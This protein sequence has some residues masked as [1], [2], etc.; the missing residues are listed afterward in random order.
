MWCA[1]RTASRLIEQAASGADRALCRTLRAAVL[2]IVPMWLAMDMLLLAASLQVM[3]ATVMGLIAWRWRKGAAPVAVP[4]F[5]TAQRPVR[6]AG[7][8]S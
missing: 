4:V 5:A 2:L 3:M 8:V 1:W 6:A 7:R